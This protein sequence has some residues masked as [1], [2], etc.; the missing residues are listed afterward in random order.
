MNDESVC[1]SECALQRERE[2]GRVKQRVIYSACVG[3]CASVSLT[4]VSFFFSFFFVTQSSTVVIK[5]STI[6]CVLV[7]FYCLA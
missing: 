4:L 1:V 3:E 6:N 5:Y 2:R 7:C